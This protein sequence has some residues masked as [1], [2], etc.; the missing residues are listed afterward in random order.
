MQQ[1]MD[2]W[3]AKSSLYANLQKA[4]VDAE[5]TAVEIFNAFFALVR[6]LRSNQQPQPASKGTH[7]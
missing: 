4:D 3:H 6:E 7:R 5:N 2:D 1:Y